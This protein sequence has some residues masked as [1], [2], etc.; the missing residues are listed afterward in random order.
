MSKFKSASLCICGCKIKHRTS[1]FAV[2]ANYSYL[3]NSRYT[4]ACVCGVVW[5][6]IVFIHMCVPVYQGTACLFHISSSLRNT[7][8]EAQPNMIAFNVSHKSLSCV[9]ASEEARA[10]PAHT[11][12]NV[13]NPW[14]PWLKPLITTQINS[15]KA[16]IHPFVKCMSAMRREFLKDNLKRK[17]W[18]AQRKIRCWVAL[19]FSVFCSDQAKSYCVIWTADI[20][21][22]FLFL[23]FHFKCKTDKHFFCQMHNCSPYVNTSQS[24]MILNVHIFT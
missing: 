3:N 6:V 7:K 9:C 1:L 15:P 2:C 20:F 16:F 19:F 10:V 14:H 23:F 8:D 22:T 11:Q 17:N 12:K 4:K 13:L 24:H 18:A 21:T 5:C